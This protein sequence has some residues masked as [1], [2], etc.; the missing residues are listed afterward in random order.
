MERSEA[1]TSSPNRWARGESKEGNGGG[2]S[3]VPRGGRRMGE[4]GRAR[5]NSVDHGVRMAPGGMVRGGSTHSCRRRAG[6]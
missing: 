2:G 5:H 4:R 6:E 1:P 3:L